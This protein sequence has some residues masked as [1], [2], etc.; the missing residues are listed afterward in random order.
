MEGL[1]IGSSKQVGSV[2][3]QQ[4]C[5]FPLMVWDAVTLSRWA[6]C[7][8]RMLCGVQCAVCWWL[9]GR[10]IRAWNAP[11]QTRPGGCCTT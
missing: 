11:S 10:R 7:T 5:S 2:D 9:D 3:R 1:D 4:S 6:A 8:M